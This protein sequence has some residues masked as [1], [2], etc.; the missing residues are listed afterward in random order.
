MKIHSSIDIDL[1]I[2]I[3]GSLV[4]QL[5]R[6]WLDFLVMTLMVILSKKS[7]YSSDQ[8]GIFFRTYIAFVLISLRNTVVSTSVQQIRKLVIEINIRLHS[9]LCI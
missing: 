8:F 1:F 2:L 6:A 4:S 7:R 5:L 9:T 3:S